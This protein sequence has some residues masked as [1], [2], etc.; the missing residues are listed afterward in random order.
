M[1]QKKLNRRNFLR[2]SA[3]S[4]LGLLAVH[5][6]LQSC[7]PTTT[8]TIAAAPAGEVVEDTVFRSAGAVDRKQFGVGLQLYSIR[9]SM[10][11]D[12]LGSLKKVSDIGYKYVEL[13]DYANRKFYGYAPADFKKVLTDL[14]LEAMSSHTQVEAAGITVDN[15]KVMADDHAALGV[16]YCVQ[17]WLEEPDRTIEKYKRM[18]TDWNKIG[19]IMKGVGIQFAYHNHN[20]E[21][22][23]TDG[24]VPYYD[25]FLKELQPDLVTMEI[26]L[27]WVT[28]AGQDAIEMFNKYPGRFKLWHFK[29][30]LAPAAPI[31]TVEKEDIA[32]VGGGRINF[33][34]IYA[35]RELAGMQNFFVED[36]NQAENYGGP[37]A[38]IERSIN[39]L[40]TKILV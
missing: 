20:F 16:K 22:L 31:Y 12:A 30:Q 21:F 6:L 19:E 26:D 15:A 38:G 14:G 18:M 36:D 2:A 37:F 4:S 28:K 7:K 13:A 25:I 39:S 8:T 40:T 34:R 27:Y 24:I 10:A 17:P 5:P 11:A 32:P 3:A 23:P 29:D 35:A 1:Q 9:D 33:N